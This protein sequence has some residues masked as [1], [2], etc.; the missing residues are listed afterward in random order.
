MRK[1]FRSTTLVF[2]LAV[3]FLTLSAAEVCFAKSPKHN[4]KHLLTANHYVPNETIAPGFDDGQVFL[5]HVREKVSKKIAE[6]FENWDAEGNVV[7]FV[8]GATIPSVVLFDADYKTYNWMAYLAD[9]GL[10]VFAVEMIGYGGSFRPWQMNDPCNLSPSQ[11][12]GIGVGPCEPSYPYRLTSSESEWDDIDAVVDYLRELRGVERISL[13]G[14]SAR[15]PRMSGYAA[16][17]P[18][19]VDKLIMFGVADWYQPADPP[20]TLPSPGYPM[21]YSTPE[22]IEAWWSSTIICKDQRDPKI[23]DFFNE[24]VL[25]SDPVGA[26]WGTGVW[27]APN[28]RR[29]GWTAERVGTIEALTLFIGGEYD[30][31]APVDRVQDLYQ[32]FTSAD[33]KVQTIVACA[34]HFLGFEKRHN[35]LHEATLDWLVNGSIKG[36]TRGTVYVNDKGKYDLQPE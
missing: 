9:A 21:R 27:R 29:W 14:V 24:I 8:H 12:A 23:V 10:D 1:L 36:L 30:D 33:D 22:G 3:F 13:I 5:L 6:D 17:H 18:E 28:V 2:I 35:I 11:Q 15:G 34:S 7:L 26:T 31:V 16:L 32:D 20:A 25:Q 19:K 4:Q